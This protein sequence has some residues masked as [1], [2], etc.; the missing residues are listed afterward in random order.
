MLSVVVQFIGIII[1]M[2]GI[3]AARSPQLVAGAI[4]QVE[5]AGWLR[6]TAIAKLA[7]GVVLLIA[8]GD[9]RLPTLARVLGAGMVLGAGWG[10][11]DSARLASVA[12]LG[13]RQG[14]WTI[15]LYGSLAM[16]AGSFLVYASR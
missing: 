15:R 12:Q 13:Q 4:R 1:A 5:E 2:M 9:T 10:L 16:F 8:A 3:V 14:V 11:S 6:V 7:A